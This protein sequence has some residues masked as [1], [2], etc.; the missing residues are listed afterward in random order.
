VPLPV[1][2]PFRLP[3]F[4]LLRIFTRS[5]MCGLQNGGSLGG[6]RRNARGVEWSWLSFAESVEQG[7]VPWARGLMTLGMAGPLT[8]WES[9]PPRRPLKGCSPFRSGHLIR[10][11]DV[12]GLV[13]SSFAQGTDT[14][15]HPDA[16]GR[17]G[18]VRP[19]PLQGAA[20]KLPGPWPK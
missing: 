8:A 16:L 14:I 2:T 17:S 9:P 1:L 6:P 11:L 10:C 4:A 5:T 15:A 19:A 3:F 13:P 7:P 20:S 18:A 12:A